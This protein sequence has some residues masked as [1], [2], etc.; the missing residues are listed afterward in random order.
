MLQKNG[1]GPASPR[2]S[3]RGSLT[4]L[5]RDGSS[6][7]ITP[8]SSSDTLSSVVSTPLWQKQTDIS[9]IAQLPTC[10]PPAVVERG[11]GGGVCYVT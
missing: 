8:S 9:H 3:K 7:L 6:Q 1:A 5:R 2:N 11:G 10:L 4:Y